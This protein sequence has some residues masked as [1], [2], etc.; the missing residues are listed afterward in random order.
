MPSLFCH[1]SLFG[2]LAAFLVSGHLHA[3][4]N[5]VLFLVDDMGWTDWQR[6]A[7]L[8]PTGSLLYETPN[9]LRLAQQGQNL[10][11]AYAACPV[12]SPTRA[13]ITTGKTP[14]RTRIT[15]WISGSGVS[16]ANLTQPNWTKNL[17]ASETTIAEA[18]SA[19][20][21]R[22][23]FFGKWHLGQAGNAGADPLQNGFDVNVGGGTF[24]NPGSNG[25]FF[26]GS[27]GAWAQMPGLNTPGTYPSDKYLSDALSEKAAEFIADE[28]EGPFFL[29]L[30]H[31][32]V[33]TPLQGPADLVA[34]YQQKI[35]TLQSQGVNLQEHDNPTYA[36]MVEKMDQSLGALLDSLE[37]P[38]GDG[39]MSDSIRDNTLIVFA[40]DNGGL[41][42]AEG[43]PT[44]NL[45][46]RDGKGSMYE[47][48][49]RT[50]Q[51]VSWTG[52]A[53]IAQGVI[54]TARTSSEDLYPTFLD[55]AGALG[56]ATVPQ[57]TD[58]DGV[59]ILS[60][61]E[62]QA[63]D[64]GFQFWHY[65]HVSPQD[66]SSAL[67]SGG[68]FVSAVRDDQWKLIFFYEDRHY[69]LY[70]LATDLSETTNVLADNPM[71]A[72][73]LSQALRDY[74]IDVDAQMPIS[75]AT[76]QPVAA[77]NVLFALVPGD[78]NN[79]GQIDPEDW[80]I[81]RQ[82]LFSDVSN[83]DPQA[84]YALGDITQD[85]L[86]NRFDF[87]SFREAYA[88]AHGPN[89][90]SALDS[91]AVPEPGSAALIVGSTLLVLLRQL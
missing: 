12:C 46:L 37:D 55:A 10:T 68:S 26:A 89:A 85:G 31:Y 79:S 42:G 18:L 41:Y 77:P 35:S 7:Q 8:N 36:A 64:R 51:I 38:N 72:L 1:L 76:G 56:S 2:T 71:V 80:S 39:N 57:N 48:G 45:P 54:S 13:A 86:I 67:I 73:N 19:D 21:Y 50:P 28:A 58:I 63:Y 16:T 66:N 74:L 25:G 60:A 30:A 75:R 17:A 87:A 3:K 49:I 15:D 47:G 90:L 81:L 32:L 44:R 4:P 43:S 29:E 61:L 24:G 9:M 69:E 23:G 62:G 53:S 27:D 14:A 5:V 70:N 34:K 52:N 91:A 84:A 65:P 11:N 78:F 22:T 20:G 33:H 88:A 6:D 83:L 82:N 40:S 59:S